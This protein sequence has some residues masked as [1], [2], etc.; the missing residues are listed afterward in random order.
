[1]MQRKERIV[2]KMTGGIAGLFRKNQVTWLQGHGKLLSGGTTWKV[3]VSGGKENETVEAR[4]VIIATGSRARELPGIPVDNLM[5]CDNE[6]A[7]AF[8][9]P[10][11]IVFQS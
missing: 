7:L 1:M 6:G 8:E 3:E 4:N 2:R 5:V 9:A 11:N 10:E